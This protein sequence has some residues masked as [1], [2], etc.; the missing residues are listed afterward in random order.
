MRDAAREAGLDANVRLL[1]EPGRA[2]VAQAAVTLYRVGAVKPVA[3]RTY[4]AVDGGM[5]DNPRPVLYGSGYEAF[6]VGRPARRARPRACA[7][8]ASTARAATS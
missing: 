5:S 1:A 6:D 2:I 4:M 3:Q 7:S 8:S